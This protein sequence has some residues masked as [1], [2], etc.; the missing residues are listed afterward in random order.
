MSSP[1]S[2]TD[3]NENNKHNQINSNFGNTEQFNTS[4]QTNNNDNDN[5]NGNNDKRNKSETKHL[6]STKNPN[7]D[8]ISESNLPKGDESYSNLQLLQTAISE[9]TPTKEHPIDDPSLMRSQSENYQIYN[10]NNQSLNGSATQLNRSSNQTPQIRPQIQSNNLFQQHQPK[11]S[12]HSYTKLKSHNRSSSHTKI[13]MNSSKASTAAANGANSRPNLNRSKSTDGLTKSNN[14]HNT[15]LKRNNRS[16]TKLAGLQPLTRTASNQSIKSTLRP[17]TKTISNQSNKSNTSLKGLVPQ[18]SNVVPLSGLKTSGKKGKAILKLNDDYNDDDYESQDSEAEDVI[19]QNSNSV[20]P[21]TFEQPSKNLIIDDIGIVDANDMPVTQRLEP[22]LSNQNNNGQSY[23]IIPNPQSSHNTQGHTKSDTA[24]LLDKKKTYLGDTN[25]QDE[26]INSQ[27]EDDKSNK[28]DPKQSE[29]NEANNFISSSM[30]SSA[31][32]LNNL[33]GGSLLLSQSTGL[34][35]KIDSKAVNPGYVYTVVNGQSIPVPQQDV[36]KISNGST[37][38]SESISGISFKANPIDNANTNGNTK[39]AEPVTTSKN[40]IP[41]NSYQPNQSIFSNLKRTN[42]QYNSNKKPQQFN[43]GTN[44]FA[45]FLNSNNPANNNQQHNN[46]SNVNYM[47]NNKSVGDTQANNN[48]S[49]NQGNYF[50]SS[51]HGTRTQQRL[52]LQRENSLIDMPN[53]DNHKYSTLSNISLS[54]MMFA[55]YNHSATNLR[56]YP[57]PSSATGTGSISGTPINGPPIQ[58]MTSINNGSGHASSTALETNSNSLSNING[59]L[60]NAQNRHQNLLQSRTEFERLNREYLNVRRHLNPVAESLNRVEEIIAKQKGID[61]PKKNNG[62][63]NTN[64]IASLSVHDESKNA[65]SFKEF[66]PMFQEKESEVINSL[67]KIWN[68]AS[69]QYSSSRLVNQQKNQQQ[70]QP[71]HQLQP[72]QSQQHPI[73]QQLQRQDPRASSYSQQAGQSQYSKNIRSMQP[74]TRKLA[75]QAAAQQQQQ[76]QQQQQSRG[77]YE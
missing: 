43:N 67:E 36:S 22:N 29:K 53:A 46:N 24:V 75:A 44:N 19:S 38:N 60:L 40:V 9:E 14:R 71:L 6:V 50:D 42:T 62:K 51:S 28:A 68:D 77:V 25:T 17:L 8:T 74:T 30:Q 56:D 52:W 58:A 69:I 26:E 55:N 12:H 63:K 34:T 39:I 1:P 16:L 23:N 7:D 47:A 5:T 13:M 18:S 21:E 4:R 10:S 33:Y 35:K 48:N 15:S 20:I 64:T 65:N 73:Q 37:G 54:K 49:L 61:L 45:D 59:L 72:Q 11:R 32:D 41:P 70:L 2:N 76:K 66:S 31:D 57:T 3:G 27:V